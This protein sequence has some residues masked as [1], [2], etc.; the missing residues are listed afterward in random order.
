MDMNKPIAVDKES[1]DDHLRQIRQYLRY[2][3]RR[4]VSERC[5]F[6]CMQSYVCKKHRDACDF[7]CEVDIFSIEHAASTTHFSVATMLAFAYVHEWQSH[8][9]C[10]R[11]KRIWDVL[12]S[13]GLCNTWPFTKRPPE[14]LRDPSVRFETGQGKWPLRAIVRSVFKM[15]ASSICTPLGPWRFIRW[16]QVLACKNPVVCALMNAGHVQE[17]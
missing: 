12:G 14:S 15:R 4:R 8:E 13:G 2:S 11:K 17:R 16:R 10:E 5:L 3:R 1:L 6:P 7:P 9:T